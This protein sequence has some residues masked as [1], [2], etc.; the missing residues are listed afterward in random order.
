M[1][2]EPTPYDESAGWDLVTMLAQAFAT[3]ASDRGRMTI[4][5]DIEWAGE[6]N[7]RRHRTTTFWS[8]TALNLRGVRAA[9]DAAMAA[10]K[11]AE[12]IFSR[13]APK[14]TGAQIRFL[15]RTSAGRAV[16][17]RAGLSVTD[18][19]IGRWLAGT[20][21][22]NK[23]NLARIQ[24]AAREHHAQRVNSAQAKSERLAVEAAY[25][26]T[27]AIGEPVRFFDVS[28]LDFN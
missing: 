5:A 3:W 7:P 27:D 24:E 20:Q 6:Y 19:T 12:T 4:T 21:K 16:W 11:S 1:T 18:R 15:R 13:P 23:A 25:A 8:H 28:D 9:T 14:S 26:L 10:R 22:P 17:A 2:G